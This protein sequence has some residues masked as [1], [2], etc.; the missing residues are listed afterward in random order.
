MKK[1]ILLLMLVVA[2]IKG[3]SAQE[4]VAVLKSGDVTKTYAGFNALKNAYTDAKDGDLITLSSGT[5]GAV[6]TIE[7]SIT[8]RGAGAYIDGTYKT[9][10]TYISGNFTIAK[11]SVQIE[12]IHHPEGSII[13]L[14]ANSPK[15]IKCYLWGIRIYTEVKDEKTYWYQVNNAYFLHCQI[16]S[17]A[18]CPPIGSMSFINCQVYHPQTWSGNASAMTFRNCVV[19]MTYY[20]GTGTSEKQ[21]AGLNNIDGSHT[22]VYGS[23]FINSVIN[24]NTS[25]YWYTNEYTTFTNCLFY[26]KIQEISGKYSTS[27]CWS[28]ADWDNIFVKDSWYVFTDTSK[29]TY[30]DEFGRE[31]GIRGGTFPWSNRVAGP[32]I[33]SMEVA[34]RSTADGKLRVKITVQNSSY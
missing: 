13:W 16:V 14:K 22:H 31:I 6:A 32:H 20:N 18:N 29:K 23:T 34:P 12:G 9:Q 4:A 8:I 5:F 24:C 19:Y 11:N 1:L 21:K 7:K 30:L 2:G 25:T 28:N 10:P 26:P 33:K 27:G 15:F 17:E 3:A